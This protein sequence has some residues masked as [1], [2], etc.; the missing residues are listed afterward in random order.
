MRRRRALLGAGAAVVVALVLVFALRGHRR[1]GGTAPVVKKDT[2]AA[3]RA[4]EAPHIP[5][6]RAGGTKLTGFVV[7]GAGLPV[8]G[9]EVTAELEKG[10]PDKALAGPGAR[11]GSGAGSGSGANSGA[12]ARAGSAAGAGTGS[13]SGAAAAVAVALPTGLDGHFIIDGIAPGRYRLRVTGTGT[14]RT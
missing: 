3:I 6:A 7:D 12:G 8:T 1:A 14:N 4:P 10:A 5:A 13:G 9:A 2:G 11:A